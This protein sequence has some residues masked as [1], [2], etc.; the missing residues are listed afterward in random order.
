[1]TVYFKHSNLE[2]KIE[3]ADIPFS[4]I[5]FIEKGRILSSC[6]SRFRFRTS[7][8]CLMVVLLPSW[9]KNRCRALIRPTLQ[10]RHDE[11]DGVSYH[12]RLDCLLNRLFRCRSKKT[13]KLRATG[14]CAGNSPVTGEFHTQRASNAENVSIWWRHHEWNQSEIK[15]CVFVFWSHKH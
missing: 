6:P 14:L 9:G 12:Q 11:C 2:T 3:Y 5:F 10:W 8:Y 13:S 1:M 4:S 7:P 15:P